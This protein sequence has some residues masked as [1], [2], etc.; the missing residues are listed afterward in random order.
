MHGEHYSKQPQRGATRVDEFSAE[1]LV[2]NRWSKTSITRLVVLVVS[3]FHR[4]S[5]SLG[6]SLME[7]PLNDRER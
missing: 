7:A 4:Q 3:E 6:L 1:T 2:C 5:G